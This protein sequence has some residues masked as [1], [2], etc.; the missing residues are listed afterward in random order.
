MSFCLCLNVLKQVYLFVFQFSPPDPLHTDPV[1]SLDML[2]GSQFAS[3]PM[4]AAATNTILSVNTSQGHLSSAR[5]H[6]PLSLSSGVTSRQV[7]LSSSLNITNTS[8][9]KSEKREPTTS[10]MAASMAASDYGLP[11]QSQTTT[12]ITNLLYTPAPTPAQDAS[13][14][15]HVKQPDLVK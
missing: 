13:S 3:S 5:T 9:V 1:G 4:S 8:P 15:L 10:H 12:P 2:T 11:S 6:P 14:L 7:P